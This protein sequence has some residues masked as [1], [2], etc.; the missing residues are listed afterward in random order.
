VHARAL[1]FRLVWAGRAVLD[2]TEQLVAAGVHHS[3]SEMLIS[4][5]IKAKAAAASSPSAD[6]KLR[7]P[8]MTRPT[9][10]AR[11]TGDGRISI[12]RV[13]NRSRHHFVDLVGRGKRTHAIHGWP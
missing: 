3:D 9:V 6:L 12:H 8:K 13:R 4:L 11:M 5:A 7:I 2:A 10:A 1:A